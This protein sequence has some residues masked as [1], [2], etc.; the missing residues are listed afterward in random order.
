MTYEYELIGLPVLWHLHVDNTNL[1]ESNI[2]S[3]DGA[4]CSLPESRPSNIGK[5]GRL[6]TAHLKLAVQR[7]HAPRD[8]LSTRQL[9]HGPE[10]GRPIYKPLTAGPN[11]RGPEQKHLKG[12][13][14]HRENGKAE[15]LGRHLQVQTQG[16]PALP[17][18]NRLYVLL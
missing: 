8:Q 11:L 14:D 2:H 17:Y 16:H 7:G 3:L 5:L 10:R 9:P 4:D 1:L 13:G 18:V 6:M 12:R 15:I